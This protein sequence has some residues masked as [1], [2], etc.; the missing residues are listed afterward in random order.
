MK[1]VRS[2]DEHSVIT[3]QN[4]EPGK[5]QIIIEHLLEGK[6]LGNN[7]MFSKA[8]LLPGDALPEHPHDGESESYYILSGE[9]IY[10][11]CG[12]EH[13]VKA[14]DITYCGDGQTHGMACTGEEPLVFIALIIKS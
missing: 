12:N 2:K 9:G 11:D 13:K 5:G 14:G 8:I 3:R 6:E 7:R 4:K 1:P 10:T